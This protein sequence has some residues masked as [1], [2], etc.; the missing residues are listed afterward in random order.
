MILAA[1]TYIEAK[2]LNG[3]ETAAILSTT[4]MALLLF[5]QLIWVGLESK[6]LAIVKR[7]TVN[8]SPI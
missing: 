2:D 5:T 7:K 8:S 1:A 3:Y 4:Y 6:I